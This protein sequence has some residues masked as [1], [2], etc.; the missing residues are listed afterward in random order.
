MTAIIK[1]AAH[2]ITKIKQKRKPKSENEWY[3]N[4]DNNL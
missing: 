1:R 2:K 4:T 3:L